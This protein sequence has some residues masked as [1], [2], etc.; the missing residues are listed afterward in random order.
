[1]GAR[2]RAA[3]APVPSPQITVS[4]DGRPPQ[5]VVTGVCESSVGAQGI[6]PCHALG[7]DIRVE[8]GWRVCCGSCPWPGIWTLR[9]AWSGEGAR[10][11]RELESVSAALD[12]P[13]RVNLSGPGR[14]WPDSAP[15]WRRRCSYGSPRLMDQIRKANL[16]FWACRGSSGDINFPAVWYLSKKLPPFFCHSHISE[17]MPPDVMSCNISCH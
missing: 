3:R 5:K 9:A 12:L 1:M 11:T 14:Q 10:H 17:T 7:I 15:S 8:K 13:G 2:S 6:L 4:G 16:G